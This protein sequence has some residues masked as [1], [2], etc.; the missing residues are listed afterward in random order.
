LN[1]SSI[2]PSGAAATQMPDKSP[3]TSAQKTGTPAAENCS[4][5]TC[6][7]TV[8]PVPVAPATRPCRLDRASSRLCANL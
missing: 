3:F 7:V 1:F 5:M 8:L 4:A 6:S 2:L